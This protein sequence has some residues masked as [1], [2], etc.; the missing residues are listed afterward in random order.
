MAA[1]L[2]RAAAADACDEN[3]QIHGTIVNGVKNY[4]VEDTLTLG[5]RL[6]VD[7]DMTAAVSQAA[8]FLD[9]TAVGAQFGLAIDPSLRRRC[10]C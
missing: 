3:L 8:V 7:G 4:L 10:R 2:T 6:I 1:L 5:P 9:N